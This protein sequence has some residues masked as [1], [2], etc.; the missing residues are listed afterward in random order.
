MLKDI[1]RIGAGC[2]HAVTSPAHP[3]VMITRNVA[4][5]MNSAFHA[6]FPSARAF[7]IAKTG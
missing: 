3:A 6:E 4:L 7:M 2:E 1:T 5:I